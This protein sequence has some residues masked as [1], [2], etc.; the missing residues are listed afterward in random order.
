MS[1]KSAVIKFVSPMACSGM[2]T[3]SNLYI[4]AAKVQVLDGLCLTSD[5]PKGV[6]ISQPCGHQAR[7]ICHARCIILDTVIWKELVMC[8]P[9]GKWSPLPTCQ[10]THTLELIRCNRVSDM[11]QENM[12]ACVKIKI[13]VPG[14]VATPKA[15]CPDILRLFVKF[16]SCRKKPETDCAV[17]CRNDYFIL[18]CLVNNRL[19]GDCNSPAPS[20]CPELKYA[21]LVNCSRI[22]GVTCKIRCPNGKIAYE[23]TFCLPVYEWSPLPACDF[24]SQCKKQKLPEK[25]H[26]LSHR[27][28]NS[29]TLYCRVG[30]KVRVFSPTSLRTSQEVVFIKDIHCSP[31]G[32]WRGLPNCGR[33]EKFFWDERIKKWQCAKPKLDKHSTIQGTCS[34]LEGSVCRYK[35]EKG[36]S[37]KG[38]HTIRCLKKR[39]HGLYKCE[40]LLC[41][42]L[43][44]IYELKNNCPP[45]AHSVCE[46][47]C[48]VG[49]L[50][51]KSIIFCYPSGHWS[52]L[53]L[54]V[55]YRTCPGKMSPQIVFVTK[56]TFKEGEKCQVRCQG[57]LVLAGSHFVICR[58]GK[59]RDVPDC[60]PESETPYKPMEIKCL[61]T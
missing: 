53:P 17:T 56:C 44:D 39:W 4:Y 27:C 26:F 32:E 35:C 51:G 60:F 19:P 3:P 55:P 25:L 11:S 36:F 13:T 33:A 18:V 54:C 5:L 59:W 49:E 52:A 38:N 29:K 2:R 40:P 50:I 6:R 42:K 9:H 7:D 1:N 28:K 20:L 14:T 41:P 10:T 15:I 46:T 12:A 21:K 8:M 61:S 16:G 58:K 22:Q 45:V 43:P 57:R 31:S 37:A 34:Y 24:R 30:C 47:G 23:E 48:R